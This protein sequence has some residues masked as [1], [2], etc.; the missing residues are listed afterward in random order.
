M[1]TLH[2]PD[3]YHDPV[4]QAED[5]DTFASGDGAGV[6]LDS[7]I[8]QRIHAEE[9]AHN[10]TEVHVLLDAIADEGIGTRLILDDLFAV[11]ARAAEMAEWY[12]AYAD[13]L[14]DLESE[15]RAKDDA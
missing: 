4:E 1:S 9:A 6:H 10:L 15:L 12:T 8:E 2:D 7:L 5:Y 14:G 11:Q 13:A 3:D